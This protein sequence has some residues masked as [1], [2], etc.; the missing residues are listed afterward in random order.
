MEDEEKIPAITRLLDEIGDHEIVGGYYASIDPASDTPDV[1]ILR[2]IELNDGIIVE[3]IKIDDITPFN[4]NPNLVNS[5]YK[6]GHDISAHYCKM[7][8]T[9]KINEDNEETTGN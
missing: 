5:Y 8:F 9:I 4:P 6:K 2:R 1:Q 7:R 3:R